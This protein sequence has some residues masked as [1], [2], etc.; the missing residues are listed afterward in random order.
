MGTYTVLF[1]LVPG[2]QD[3]IAKN[4]LASDQSVLSAR[5]LAINA[6]TGNLISCAWWQRQGLELSGPKKLV[7]TGMEQEQ[8]PDSNL[9]WY[10][11]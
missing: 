11:Y 5:V 6:S 10:V 3:A 8:K 1:L 2:L 9:P 7:D 4:L